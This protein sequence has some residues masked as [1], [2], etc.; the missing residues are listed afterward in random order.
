MPMWT[1][2][3][4]PCEPVGSHMT[5]MAIDIS[6]ARGWG[7]FVFLRKIRNENFKNLTGYRRRIGIFQQLAYSLRHTL[8]GHEIY[9]ARVAGD[10]AGYVLIDTSKTPHTVTEVVS[11]EYRKKGV[12]R[13]L[14]LFVLENYSVQISAIINKSNYASLA[15]HRSL[16]F[17]IINQDDD[18]VVML[19]EPR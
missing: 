3:A 7:D 16:G 18:L 11:S 10:R 9:I 17:E 8:L 12:G 15:L 1:E 2:S 5:L 13:A 6:P 14:V 4:V 19:P